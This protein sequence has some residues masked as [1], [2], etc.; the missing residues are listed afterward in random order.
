MS[1]EQSNEQTNNDTNVDTK[2]ESSA[3]DAQTNDASAP[4][5]LWSDDVKGEGN[6]PSWFN[7]KTFKNISEQAKAYPELR[8]ELG[9][10]GKAPD[11]Y[12]VELGDDYKDIKFKDDDPLLNWFKD[13]AKESNIP[14]DKFSEALKH[15]VDFNKDYSKNL[16]D[17]R[18]AS[19]ED[20]LKSLGVN[21]QDTINNLETWITQ[22]FDESYAERLKD[23]ATD[24]DGI[25]LLIN[26]RDKM[27]H[28]KIATKSEASKS[29][30]PED[31]R[32]MMR[33]ERYTRDRDYQKTVDSLYSKKYS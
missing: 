27:T 16:T 28:Q 10:R 29:Y 12:N 25:K 1:N 19:I 20:G 18:Q 26:M 32:A 22:T 8:K 2:I 14:Q 4:N 23:L 33:D 9:K 5:W 3:Q 31:L 6:K 15:W 13:Y 7:E 24:F 30:S 21:G 11:A 17:K